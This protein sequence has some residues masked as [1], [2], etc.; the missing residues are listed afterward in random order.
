MDKIL[1]ASHN[2]GKIKEFK[3]ILEPL[4]IE[5]ISAADLQLADVEETG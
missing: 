3:E 2:Q 4:G 1:I 5:V